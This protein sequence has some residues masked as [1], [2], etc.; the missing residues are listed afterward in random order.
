MSSTLARYVT[1][2]P[3]STALNCLARVWEAEPVPFDK[4]IL[5]SVY[6]YADFLVKKT[7][8][9]FYPAKISELVPTL[10]PSKQ[11]L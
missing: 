1:Y 4:D 10:D 5:K 11:M 2:E 6:S 7:K 9:A 8:D 3:R